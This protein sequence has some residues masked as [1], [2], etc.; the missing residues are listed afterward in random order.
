[1]KIFDASKFLE[2]ENYEQI[3]YSI[4]CVRVKRIMQ[5]NF[6]KFFFTFENKS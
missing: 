4:V 3:F 1:M 5:K 6:L 2:K